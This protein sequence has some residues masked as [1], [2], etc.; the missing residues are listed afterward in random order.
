MGESGPVSADKPQDSVR[1]CLE[2]GEAVEPGA[3]FCYRCGSKRIF[4]VGYNNRL[5]LKKGECPYCGHMNVEEAKFCASCG[6]RIGEFE[7]TPVRRRPLTGKDYLIMAITFLPGAFFI[8]G[9][10]HL[11]LKKYSRGLMFLCISAV[12]IYLRYFT[13]GS[14]GSI[15]IF[16]EVIGLLVYIKQA[17]E[18]L[19]EL[20]GGSI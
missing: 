2:C 4:Q 5:V 18:V 12:M 16:L 13:I 3:D 6:K 20:M 8:F 1:Y 10:G 11:A 9:L 19:S 14:G 7:Y 15:Y 17:M